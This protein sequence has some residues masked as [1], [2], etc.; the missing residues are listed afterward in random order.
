MLL[1]SF[2]GSCVFS[3]RLWLSRCSVL[4]H[5]ADAVLQVVP[6]LFASGGRSF[7]EETPQISLKLFLRLILL[8][9]AAIPYS[10]KY[11]RYS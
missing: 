11:T 8:F 7:W 6:L 5:L 10:H 9:A 1:W 4:Q 2:S 3:C